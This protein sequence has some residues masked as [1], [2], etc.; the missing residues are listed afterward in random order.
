MVSYIISGERAVPA[1]ISSRI[2]I[3]TGLRT[4]QIGRVFIPKGRQKSGSIPA[5]S[6]DPDPGDGT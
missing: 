1:W 6:D 3:I 5:G 4:D 2:A